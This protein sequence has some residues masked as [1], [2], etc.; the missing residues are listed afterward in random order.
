MK[1]S[2]LKSIILS[3]AFIF[4]FTGNSRA[5]GF[6]NNS[7]QKATENFGSRNVYGS[8]GIGLGDP[9]NPNGD[10]NKNGEI[11]ISATDASLTPVESG[12]GI[13]IC[14]GLAYGG[15]LFLR[16]RTTILKPS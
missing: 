16:K 8:G 4:V 15:Y 10:P 13:L 12:L 14:L 3:V 6:G 7:M 5:D 11:P 1:K 9:N 2:Y